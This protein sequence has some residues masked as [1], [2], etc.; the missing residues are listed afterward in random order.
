MRDFAAKFRAQIDAV[1]VWTSLQ[2]I[3]L[4]VGIVVAK[5]LAVCKT[6]EGDP[7][8]TQVMNLFY[9]LPWDFLT[10]GLL[11]FAAGGLSLMRQPRRWIRILILLCGY[12]LFALFL[13]ITFVNEEFY[14]SFG[15][16]LKYHLVALAPAVGSELL[17]S[18][19]SRNLAAI[20]GPLSMIALS[21]LMS[22]YLCARIDSAAIPRWRRGIFCAAAV[23][24]VA[25][26]GL[27]LKPP[28]NMRAAALRDLTL[29]A[30]FKPEASARSALLAPASPTEVKMLADLCD[31]EN[32]DGAAAFSLLE[33]KKYNIVIWVWESVGL[34]YLKSYHPLGVARTPNLDRLTAAGSVNFDHCHCESPL[35]VQTGWSLVTGKSPP[36][37]PII[38]T[39]G[40][41]LPE[42]ASYLPALLKANGYQTA[43]LNS[44]HLSVWNMQRFFGES[45]FDLLE[46]SDG[47]PAIEKQNYD[48]HDWG[49]DD[50]FLVSRFG[51]W[52]D[53][54]PKS[55]PFFGMLWNI[56]TH[57]P[58]IWHGMSSADGKAGD[59]DSYIHCIEYS[60]AL[61]GQAYDELT[62]RG[63]AENT[64]FI[65]IGDHGEG[66][67]R[68]PRSYERGH[69]MLVF[70]DSIHIPLFFINPAFKRMHTA[71]L[72]CSPVDLYSTLLALTQ[73]TA[74][75]SD[76]HS[77]MGSVPGQPH[78]SRS[79][80]WWPVS[81][82]AGPYKLVLGSPEQLPELYN[83]ESDPRETTDIAASH[84]DITNVLTAAVLRMSADRYKNDPS[85][86]FGFSL[87]Q[88]SSPNPVSKRP[89][90]SELL[91]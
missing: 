16:P 84:V 62:K 75:E 66:M 29:V 64:I 52:L 50:R 33:K 79:I 9:A 28:A 72:Q 68:P 10:L 32:K 83:V 5:Y 45:G 63:L 30:V 48:Q 82:R 91:K 15:S 46:D 89:P 85:F 58:Y 65:I 1:S 42:H 43:H 36:A 57:H 4:F 81:V 24:T 53:A 60:D 49:V 14:A 59:L 22:P 87:A 51:Q 27:Y 56:E 19:V 40:K 86:E 76:G 17:R 67:G 61:L 35:T 80:V 3:L 90:V 78:F 8:S 70:E 6:F 26:I 7:F 13:A 54:V 21:L 12:G 39:N 41:V 31:A 2:I 18:G 69:S 74:G 73:S 11:L 47:I 44:S 25:G 77:L 55:S 88:P 23:A 20:A 71:A 37:R 38:F 34:R